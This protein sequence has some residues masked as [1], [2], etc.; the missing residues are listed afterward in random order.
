MS[1]DEKSYWISESELQELCT[2]SLDC[3]LSWMYWLNGKQFN[4]WYVDGDLTSADWVEDDSYVKEKRRVF[5]RS[6]TQWLNQ[7]DRKHLARVVQSAH[8][9]SQ[10]S[11]DLAMLL[12]KLEVRDNG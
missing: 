10:Q 6:Q 2:Q 1:Q 4:Q 7:F 11:Q 3:V 5:E 9:D 8:N 12:R